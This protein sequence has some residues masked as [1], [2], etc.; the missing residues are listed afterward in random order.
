MANAGQRISEYVL[1]ELIGGGVFG[2][3]WRAHH[4]VWTD[5]LVAVKIPTNP[6]YVRDLQHEGITI[7][8]LV[9][10]NIV[11]AKGFDPYADPPYLVMEFV[12]GT[13]LRPL[14]QR[15]ALAIGDAVAVMSQVLAGLSYAHEHKLVHRDIKPENILIHADAAA[16]RYARPGSVKVTDFGLGKVT[17]SSAQSIALSMSM[18]R[19]D[20]ERIVGTLDYMAPE[21][22]TNGDVDGRADLYSC[23]VLLFELLTGQRPQG[24][25]LPGDLNPD[26]PEYLDLAFMR[27][28]APLDGRNK[29]FASASEFLAA[30]KPLEVPASPAPAPLAPAKVPSAPLPPPSLRAPAR[31]VPSP[32]SSAPTRA[33]RAGAGDALVPDLGSNVKM[34]FSRI[35]A[36]AKPFKMGSPDD[37]E[38]RFDDETQHEVTITQLFMLGVHQVTVAQFEV[39]VT[40]KSYITDAEREGWSY[41]WDGK[42]WGKVNGASWRKPG[43]EQG[44]TH[45]VVCVSWKDAKAFCDWLARKSGKAACLPTEA[46]WEYACRAGTRTAY[47]WGDNPDDGK[48]W[49][50]CADLT[51]KE[52]FPNWQPVFSWHDGFVFTS[53]G[54]SFKPNAWGLCDMI[55]NAWEWCADGYGEYPGKAVSDPTG[56]AESASR[57]LRGGSWYDSPQNCRSAR[58]IRGAPDGR[59]DSV[60]FRVCLDFA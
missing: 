26:V 34:Q 17:Q 19:N 33:P 55:G 60:G 44:P 16:G 20:A 1:D 35:P 21:Q 28:Y 57:V 2:E 29:R 52:R 38:G 50:N 4:H 6:Q 18:N 39:F 15:K 14:I 10:P 7:H 31:S 12:P 25:Q 36:T 43:F 49:A 22:R 46:Q 51:A 45:P 8:G 9:H 54:G 32:A 59:Y 58:R 53:P 5:Q 48:G 23:G 27:A 24:H 47:P 56:A 11:P 30:L 41:A 13:S 37:E 3:V 40:H 42:N